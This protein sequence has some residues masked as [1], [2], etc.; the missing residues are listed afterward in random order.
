[1]SV[2]KHLKGY[3]A[4]YNAHQLYAQVLLGILATITEIDT[5]VQWAVVVMNTLVVVAL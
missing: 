5:R 2:R 3:Y 4:A 1:M